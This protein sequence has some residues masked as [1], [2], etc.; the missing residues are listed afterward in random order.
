MAFNVTNNVGTGS[1]SELL[2]FA[3]AA[4]A[5]IT[6]T[7]QAYTINGRTLTR[8]DLPELRETVDWLEQ[9]IAADGGESPKLIKV[10]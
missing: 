5:T 1:D 3:R 4:I 9:R 7:G 8:A 6:L 2:E 10:R